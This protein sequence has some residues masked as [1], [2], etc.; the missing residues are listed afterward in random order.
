MKLLKTSKPFELTSHL[1]NQ[2][3]NLWVSFVIKN[4]RLWLD[5]LFPKAQV[6]VFA[7]WGIITKLFYK[8]S[9][10]SK[11]NRK[12]ETSVA[13]SSSKGL[14]NATCRIKGY[15][16]SEASAT[17][18]TLNQPQTSSER[19]VDLS[20][21][22]ALVTFLLVSDLLFL[23]LIIFHHLVCSPGL[24]G[25]KRSCWRRLRHEDRWLWFRS[26]Y[27]QEWLICDDEQWCFANEV[28]G[29][30]IIVFEGVLREKWCV[31]TSN[32]TMYKGR[33]WKSYMGVVLIDTTFQMR[34]L[35][36]KLKRS[37]PFDF[38]N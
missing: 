3:S 16:N 27:L 20:V 22:I 29:Y 7:L 11:V 28:D 17:T 30:R 15:G 2:P 9:A 34:N 36:F 37:W 18:V 38:C 8:G 12:E 21:C 5:N 26:R 31:S 33:I 19:S 35:A 23:L 4:R 1:R 32:K 6:R 13:K 25:Q 24:G 10:N 14:E